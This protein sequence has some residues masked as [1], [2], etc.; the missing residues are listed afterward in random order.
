[1][2]FI[3]DLLELRADDADIRYDGWEHEIAQ[4]RG[5]RIRG[6]PWFRTNVTS[7]ISEAVKNFEEYM[8]SILSEDIDR[9]DDDRLWHH[10][11]FKLQ[12]ETFSPKQFRDAANGTPISFWRAVICLILSEAVARRFGRISQSSIIYK[13]MS[14]EPAVSYIYEFENKTIELIQAAKPDFLGHLAVV[15]G[16][17]STRVFSDMANG[18]LVTHKLAARVRQAIINEPSWSFE[19]GDVGS[20]PPGAGNQVPYRK[21]CSQN[22]NWDVDDD[23]VE[24]SRLR[25]AHL[26][27]NIEIDR[28]RTMS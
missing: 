22:E 7:N 10:D 3:E 27:I 11:V 6:F 16:Q 9:E 23:E 5:F 4:I 18:M 19:L 26:D 28:V 12:Q 24:R 21:K 8:H 13:K 15:T 20:K 1:M 14:I 2:P 25:L 17:R